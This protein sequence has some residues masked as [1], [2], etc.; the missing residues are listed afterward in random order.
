MDTTGRV[1]SDG[2]LEPEKDDVADEPTAPLN[3]DEASTADKAEGQPSHE[4]E[5]APTT[6]AGGHPIEASEDETE[7]A[8]R[9]AFTPPIPEPTP[10]PPEPQQPLLDADGHYAPDTQEEIA[11]Q[12]TYIE[13]NPTYEDQPTYVEDQPAYI[14]EEPTVILLPDEVTTEI[15]DDTTDGDEDYDGPLESP[16]WQQ[17]HVPAIAPA[18][19]GGRVGSLGSYRARRRRRYI[20]YLRRSS[21]ARQ[22]AR[23][24]VIGRLAWASL[25]VTGV[26]V[27]TVLTTTIGAAASYYVAQEPSIAALSRTVASKDSVRIYDDKGVLL[28]QFSNNGAQ[29][30]IP[31]AKIPVNLINATVAIEDH[32]FWVNQGVDLTSIGRAAT[33]N[34][35][36]GSI[37]QG[38]STITQQLI[39]KE[40]L[41]DNETFDRKLRE[42]ILAIGI[43]ESGTYSKSQIM[44]MYL[45]S[46]PYGAIPYGIDAAAQFYF[47]YSDNPTT[48]QTAAQQLDL[49]QA[50]LLAGVPQNPNTND[51]LNNFDTA[52]ARQRD[53]LNAMVTY[54]YITQ[55]QA[56]A[57]YAESAQKDFFHPQGSTPNLA[58]HF[59]AY[60]QQQLSQMVQSGQ[61]DLTRSGLNVYTTLDLDMQNATQQAMKNHL[62]GDERDDYTHNLIRNDHVTNAAALLVDQHNGDIK[63]MLGSVD[64]YSKKIPGGGAFN[65][66]TDGYRG[67]GSSFKPIVYATAFQK[68]WAPAM[69][70]ADLPTVFWDAG[71]SKPY[72]P[73]DFNFQDFWGT[74]TLRTA[75]QNSLN[76]PAV[77]VMQFAGVEDVERNA[78]RMGITK[79]RDGATWGLSSVLGSLDVT[80]FEMVQAYT[81]FANYGK[82]IPL[83]GINRI[84]DSLGNVLYQ[85]QVPANPPQVLSPQVAYL[86]TNV[87]SDNKERTKDFGACSPLYLYPGTSAPNG[88]GDNKGECLGWENHP[89]ANT[90]T[91]PAGANAW[92]A[93]V[94]TG[95]GQDLRDD[96]T[97][98]Y[99]NDYTMGVWAGNNDF[100]PMINMDGVT[101]AAPIWHNAMI[102]AEQGHPKQAFPIPSGVYR[103]KY[104]SDGITTTDWF[105]KGLQVPNNVGN[106]GPKDLPCIKFNDDPNNS[107]DYSNDKC[108]GR[109]KPVHY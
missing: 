30:S 56:N 107:W 44:E 67:P 2:G 32:S 1:G 37:T 45:N 7:T 90:L 66:V 12:P 73:L 29:H 68:G 5:A 82:Y 23:S 93:A 78:E 83:H 64:Y 53:V 60:I 19:P 89:S 46:V 96:W 63:V 76:I 10:L 4:T 62:Y 17:Y 65:V 98:G 40:I 71:A 79:W 6:D 99:T 22:S 21:R 58:P 41:G 35:Q 86:I 87:L 105:I 69:T 94:K 50:S 88:P 59:V 20:F 92:P 51:P 106:S 61:L 15:L 3:A 49:A 16:I 102:Y 14:D 52:H 75:L 74:I 33:A 24:G 47:G 70:V 43:T 103:A 11:D 9:R 54:G 36:Q 48:G 42:A 100:T 27:A 80:P 109:L 55:A 91:W 8:P 18:V 57:A 101:G 77:K 39:K 26:L 25:I 81:V 85:Y 72:K 97:L 28:Y 31:L 13:D 84:T 95:T 38:G 34:L 108:Q 104:T